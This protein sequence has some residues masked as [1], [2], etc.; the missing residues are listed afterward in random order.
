MRMYLRKT[1]FA[2]FVFNIAGKDMKRFKAFVTMIGFLL[3]RYQMPSKMKAVILLD[4]SINEL[5]AAL[6]GVGKSLLAK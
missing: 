6:G 2:Q 3:H 1:P 5:N 4:E